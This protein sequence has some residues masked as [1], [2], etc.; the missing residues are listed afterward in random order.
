MLNIPELFVE[1]FESDVETMLKP[2]FDQ[3]WNACGYSGP[4]NYNTDGK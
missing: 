2:I 3:I 4:K 1:D